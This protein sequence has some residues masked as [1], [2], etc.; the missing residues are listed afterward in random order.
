MEAFP[1]RRLSTSWLCGRRATRTKAG[2]LEQLRDAFCVDPGPIGHP[3]RFCER[4]NGASPLL[5]HGTKDRR[6][7]KT[8]VLLRDA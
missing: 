5:R 1:S 2:H 6:I 4:C 3:V 8:Q 7:Q